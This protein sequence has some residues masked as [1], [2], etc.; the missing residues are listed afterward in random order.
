MKMPQWLYE[1]VT[2]KDENEVHLFPYHRTSYLQKD[3]I[4]V[5]H[6]LITLP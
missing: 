5:H 1:Y 6:V 2:S 4:Q 3:I